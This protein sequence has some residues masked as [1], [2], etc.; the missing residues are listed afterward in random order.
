M[1]PIGAVLSGGSTINSLGGFSTGG[2]FGGGG[3]ING[4]PWDEQISI[5]SG[6]G[7]PQW[8]VWDFGSIT[9]KDASITFGFDAGGGWTIGLPTAGRTEVKFKPVARPSWGSCAAA[10]LDAMTVTSAFGTRTRNGASEFHPGLDLQARRPTPLFAAESG[11]VVAA[12]YFEWGNT[13]TIRSKSVTTSYLHLSEMFVDKGY[14]IE[15]GQQIGL[16]GATGAPKWIS[17]AHLHFQQQGP[18]GTY[19]AP[20]GRQR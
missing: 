4:G 2:P 8:A 15:A 14:P 17:G 9:Y 10:P 20:C 16:T 12:R 19:V 13:I 5:A 3:G 11:T 7:I 1:A 6:R 18:D